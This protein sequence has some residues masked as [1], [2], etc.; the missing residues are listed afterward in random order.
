MQGVFV[1]IGYVPNTEFVKNLVRTNSR[2]EIIIDSECKTGSKG[3]F[4][5]GDVT[6]LK[7]KQVVVSVGEG[8]KAALATV[9]YLETLGK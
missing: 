6:H 4:A 7:E 3:V 8:A 2:G 1:E 9:L 5:A